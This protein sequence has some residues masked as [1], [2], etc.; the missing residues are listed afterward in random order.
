[1]NTAELAGL[2]R[3]RSLSMTA[4]ADLVPLRELPVEHLLVHP[5]SDLAPLAGH[6]TLR[7]LG[8]TQNAAPSDLTPLRTVPN[9]HGLS[10]ASADV[11]DLAV[12]ADLPSLVY[13]ELSFDQ[14]R[15]LRRLLDATGL[16]AATLAGNPTHR[17][18]IEWRSLFDADPTGTAHRTRTARG[19]L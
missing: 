7:S 17:Q 6:P 13:L 4:P 11:A 3:L 18:A 14:W 19:R 2:R 12:L 9:L 8:L 16:H 10:L 1:M 5:G 15:Q